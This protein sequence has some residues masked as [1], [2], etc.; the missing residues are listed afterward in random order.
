MLERLD[1]Q[2]GDIEDER[3]REVFLQ[4]ALTATRIT[5]A[6]GNL[7]LPVNYANAIKDPKA[8]AQQVAEFLGMELDVSA[9]V[10]T[11]DPSLHREKA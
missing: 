10:A 6:H 11:V 5:I 1:K 9:M 7:L 2:G 4:Q 3:L 8:V